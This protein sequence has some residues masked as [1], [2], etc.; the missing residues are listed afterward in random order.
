MRARFILWA[1]VCLAF[2]TLPATSRAQPAAADGSGTIAGQ[3][4]DASSGDPIIEAGVEILGV[5][6]QIR[7]DLDGRYAVKVPAGTY[8]VRFFAPLYEGARIEKVVV[9]AGKVANAAV[10]L[11]PQGQAGVE[12]VEVVAQA[13]KA[14]EATQLVKRQKAAVV[15]D[16]IG[17]ETIRKAPDSDAA[18]IVQRVP[19]VTVKDDKFIFVRGLNERYSSAMLDG[20][21]LPSPDPERRVVPLDLFPADFLESISVMKTY[22]PDLPGDFSAGLADIELLDFPDQ[23]TYGI[24]VSTSGNANTTFHDF[25]SYDGDRHDLFTFGGDKRELP[26]LLPDR[27]V[28]SDPQAQRQL[29]GRSFAN[30]WETDET[31]APVDY[32]I[33]GQI[34]NR[35]GPV[36]ARLAFTYGSKWRRRTEAQKQFL[37]GGTP[38]ESPQAVVGDDFQFERDQLKTTLGAVFTSAWDV[39]P[40]HRLTVRALV[41]RNATDEVLTGNG[42]VEQTKQQSFPT[43]MQYTQNE[44]DYGQ[45]AGAHHFDFLD[46]DWRTAISRTTQNIPDWRITNRVVQE[47]GRTVASNDSNGG[48]RIFGDLK[49]H[50]T[51]SH[52]DFTIPFKTGLP[53]TD[54][55][56]GLPA[57]L[58][59]GPA[60][61]YRSRDSS[62]RIFSFSYQPSFIDLDPTLP[63]NDFYAPPNIGGGPPFPIVFDEIT[64]PQNK[65]EASEEI[66]AGYGML[67]LPLVKDQLRLI[68]GARAEYSYIQLDITDQNEQPRKTILNHT[69]PMPGVNLVY[70]PRPD[71]NVRL[72][73]SQTVSRPEFRELSPA[74][75]PA[76]RG[77]RGFVGNPNLDQT[78]VE[79]VDA[80]WEW[81]FGPNEL[82]SV[83]GF[84]KKIDAPIEQAVFI[85]GSAA[86][87]TFQQN[88]DG[89]LWGFEMEAR[90]NL[91]FLTPWLEGLSFQTNVT[92]VQSEVTAVAREAT[93]T[94]PAIV[95][96]RDL[97]GQS[98][99][100]VNAALEY[101]NERFGT[102][103]LLYNTVGDTIARVQDRNDLPDFEEKRRDSLDFV[104]LKKADVFGVP[105]TFKVSVENILNDKYL[106]TV[107]G[108]TQEDYRTGVTAGL[109]I[110]YAY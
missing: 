90:K 37:Q 73:W 17:A 22:T 71:M 81:F 34:G 36:G 57:K 11:K 63:F 10:P 21:R 20:S 61:S 53:G 9:E 42:I 97:Q 55:W 26:H 107:G 98:P 83:S 45:F 65:F 40:N 48:S 32:N 54:F 82:V 3:V 16:N 24:G 46:V 35:W 70:T 89:K 102:A 103:R 68:A 92:Y 62:L 25:K 7:T 49:E 5:P 109:G 18:E 43:Q 95:R 52:L 14:A 79:S 50:L 47:D 39:A 100:V 4:I 110:S 30:V 28:S 33:A 56:S 1:V 91:G 15:S 86:F 101:T 87:D 66:A 6:K 88:S 76:P 105:L 74:I 60:Y 75:Y 85:S 96:K 78:D 31:T 58:K 94:G 80:R 13:A 29:F 59:F 69:D 106:T 51:D 99:F 19:A 93:D 44:L 104:Y 108:E 41:D 2:S 77:L 84:Y 64:Q 72:G 27:S 67:E 23:L 38:F 12:V 8:A